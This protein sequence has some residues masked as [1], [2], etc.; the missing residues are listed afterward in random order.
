MAL[1]ETGPIGVY[2]PET[3]EMPYQPTY[4]IDEETGDI[5]YSEVDD[6]MLESE[7]QQQTTGTFGSDTIQEGSYTVA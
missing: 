5:I 7:T 4:L 6:L 2:E 1:V 3:G